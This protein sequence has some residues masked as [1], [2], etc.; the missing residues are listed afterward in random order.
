LLELLAR[1]PGGSSITGNHDL[2]LIRS[3]RLDGGPASA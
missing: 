1:R 2:A 3:A